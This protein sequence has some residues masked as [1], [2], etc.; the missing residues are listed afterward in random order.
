MNYNLLWSKGC[1]NIKGNMKG[2]FAKKNI[3]I[4]SFKHFYFPSS[5]SVD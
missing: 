1:T 3:E 5:A 2:S 4:F